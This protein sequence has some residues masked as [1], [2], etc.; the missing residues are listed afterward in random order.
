MSAIDEITFNP[1]ITGTIA[2]I[3]PIVSF[4]AG[5]DATPTAN[6]VDILSDLLP[7]GTFQLS[8]VQLSNIFGS[9][10]PDGAHTLHLQVTDSNGNVTT[11]DR[12]FTLDTMAPTTPIFDLAVTSDT[13][14][15]CNTRGP[16]RS[17]GQRVLA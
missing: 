4:T 3:N 5:F 17:P 15:D 16:D 8:T 10:I 11:L 6:F 7:N 9:P 12:P 1:T 13:G 2:D 14:D